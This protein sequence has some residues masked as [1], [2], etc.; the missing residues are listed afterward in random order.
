[1]NSRLDEDEDDEDGDVIQSL[2]NRRPF[3]LERTSQ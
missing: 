3:I 2:C 1:M